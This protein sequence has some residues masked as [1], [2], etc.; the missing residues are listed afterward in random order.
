MIRMKGAWDKM[1]AIKVTWKYAD[2]DELEQKTKI[3][4]NL[5][6]DPGSTRA[7][8]NLVELLTGALHSWDCCVTREE[9]PGGEIR[10]RSAAGELHFAPHAAHAS[11][12]PIAAWRGVCLKKLHIVFRDALGR[13]TPEL[14][15]RRVVS[16]ENVDLDTSDYRTVYVTGLHNGVTTSCCLGLYLDTPYC[17]RPRAYPYGLLRT[18]TDCLPAWQDELERS[19]INNVSAMLLQDEDGRLRLHVV[20]PGNWRIDYVLNP[21]PGEAPATL[22]ESEAGSFA[23]SLHH[24]TVDKLRLRLQDFRRDDEV[25]L[26]VVG[27][28]LRVITEQQGSM[29]FPAKLYSADRFVPIRIGAQRLYDDVLEPYVRQERVA[30]R[31][32]LRDGQDPQ[33]V[34]CDRC[35]D[36]RDRKVHFERYNLCTRVA[37]TLAV[38]LAQKGE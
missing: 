6:P 25:M 2:S 1:A 19:G 14:E 35:A 22:P 38:R 4:V 16:L 5:L 18:F 10:V 29:M 9:L 37:V 12:L 7:A 36:P 13:Y 32:D 28:K 30:M 34:L 11:F 20:H 15:D 27:N 31:V 24:G 3:R 21:L 26:D 17:F 23:L 33:L 8:N